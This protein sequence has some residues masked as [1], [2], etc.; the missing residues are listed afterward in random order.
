MTSAAGLAGARSPLCPLF[1]DI[2][3]SR[4][5]RGARGDARSPVIPP[6]TRSQ[7]LPH[8]QAVT[9]LS[10]RHPRRSE[11]KS[12]GPF[13]PGAGVMGLGWSRSAPLTRAVSVQGG[14]GEGPHACRDRRE[15]SHM[16][17]LPMDPRS[18]AGMTAERGPKAACRRPTLMPPPHSPRVTPAGAT[19]K[20]RGPFV[21]GATAMG[22]RWRRAGSPAP[23]VSLR[24]AA[25][26]DSPVTAG[27]SRPACHDRPVTTG[28]RTR[29]Q[30]LD[31]R[32]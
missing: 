14:G 22:T 7:P 6:A 10:A 13:V 2:S 12:G 32:R 20:S 28:Q 3:P 16:P 23:A 26:G 19:A 21:P 17:G 15:P 1:G 29:C 5:E 31:R 24:S 27:L 9:P 4:G 18:G 25:G 8:P 30:S 11:A